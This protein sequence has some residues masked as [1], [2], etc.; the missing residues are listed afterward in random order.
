MKEKIRKRFLTEGADAV[1]FAKAGE[2]DHAI[3][4]HHLQ[5]IAER[6]HGEMSYLERHLPLK[7]HTDNVLP[8]AKTV[9]SLAF[10]YVPSEWRSDNLPYIASYAYGDDYHDVIRERLSPIVEE[11]KDTYG[12]KW[13]ICIDSAPVAERY[14]ALKSGVGKRGMNGSVIVEGCGSLCFLTEILTTLELPPDKPSND[15]CGE[16]ELCLRECPTRALKGDGTM[17]ARR[18]INYLTIEKKGDMTEEERKMI[19]ADTGFLFGCDKCL[20]VCPHNPDY[21]RNKVVFPLRNEIRGL[22]AEKI[23]ESDEKDF[24]DLF[25]NSPL[26]YAG[27][28]RLRRNALLL[29]NS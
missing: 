26:L 7:L 1:G 8:G 12:G 16:C 27:F 24:K 11:F 9:I 10:S 14:W 15:T 5:W 28:S 25:K 20:K 23:L 4:S 18:C 2:I 22:S 19:K 17:D 21:P 3:H 29:H 6:N 13:R